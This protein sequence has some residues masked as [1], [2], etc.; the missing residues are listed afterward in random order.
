M[1]TETVSRL[2]G[3]ETVLEDPC[4]VFDIDTLAVVGD[5]DLQELTS[6]FSNA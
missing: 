2:L 6:H 4:L 5:L 3:R 1:Q